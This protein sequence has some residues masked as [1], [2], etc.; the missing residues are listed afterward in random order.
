MRRSVKLPANSGIRN[1]A[2]LVEMVWRHQTPVLT[3]TE[4]PYR[5]PR[6]I[7]APL[8]YR[9]L[10]LDQVEDVVLTPRGG[11]SRLP[12]AERRGCRM[13]DESRG[14]HGRQGEVE[15]RTTPAVAV[16]PDPSA[17]RFD[18]RLT[19]CQAHAA[20]LR[21]RRKERVEYVVGLAHG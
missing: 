14:I 4:T 17:M 21:L 9:G 1:R 10:P 5:V 13:A 16:G 2:W 19:D 12:L 6:S 18:D 20:A 11:R 15:R 7:P 3:R 8:V